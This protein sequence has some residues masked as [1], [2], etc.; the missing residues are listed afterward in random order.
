[1]DKLKANVLTSVILLCRRIEAWAVIKRT[2]IILI[3]QA[4]S[5]R[6]T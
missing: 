5:S 1:M 3:I 6:K 2:Q 4:V